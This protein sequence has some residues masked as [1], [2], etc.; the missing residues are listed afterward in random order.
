M[1]RIV[2]VLALT[3]ACGGTA[4][5]PPAPVAVAISAIAPPA[6]AADLE[7][8][9]V[10]GRP[11]WASCIGEQLERHASLNRDTALQ[12]CIAFE[13]MAQ[14]AEKR[15]LDTFSEVTDATRTSMVSRFIETAFEAK[16]KTP[17]DLGEF[18]TK[19]LD[20]ESWRL[21]RPELRGSTYIRLPVAKDAAPEVDAQ[22]KATAQK[23]AD[24]LA[25][26]SGLSSSTFIELAQRAVPGVTFEQSEVPAKPAIGLDK[27][28]GDALFAVP[29]VGKASG[30]VRTQWGYDIILWTGGLEAK[31]TTRDELAHELF[32]EIRRAYFAVWVGQI[33]KERGV[34]IEV[35]PE[36]LN[37]EGQTP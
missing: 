10:N 20:K 6:S 26:E 2:I 30:L 12:E 27:I 28:Y 9:R 7:V 37:E 21:S 22:A 19:I 32:P 17:A 31:E 29:E 14:E 5:A 13:L 3:A 8:A 35:H 16:Y 11:V 33:V 36:Q 1:R 4:S 18:M 25:N 23:I 24:A 15:H 34:Q